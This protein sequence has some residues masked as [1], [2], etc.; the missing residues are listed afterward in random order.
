MRRVLILSDAHLAPYVQGSGPWLAYRRREESPDRL[1]ASVIDRALQGPAPLDV[2][3][4]GDLFDF[5]APP[6]DSAATAHSYALARSDSGAAIAMTTI[7]V[8][9]APFFA[10]LGRVLQRGGRV[11]VLPGNHDAQLAFPSVQ[12]VLRTA[13]GNAPNLILRPWFHKDGELF[14]EHGHQ[15]D[16][17]CAMTSLVP[18]P[19]ARG[20]GYPSQLEDTVGSVSTHFGQAVFGLSNP[21]VADPFAQGVTRSPDVRE[22]LG[23]AIANPS[24]LACA[25]SALRELMTLDR[26]SETAATSSFAPMPPHAVLAAQEVAAPVPVLAAHA[27]LA[28][29]K[30]D[31]ASLAEAASRA[32]DYG[33]DVEARQLEAMRRIGLLYSSRAV[34]MGHTHA[35]FVRTENGVSLVNSGSWVPASGDPS[36]PAGTFVDALVDP[37]GRLRSIALRRAHRDGTVE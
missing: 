25:M 10:A 14:I 9:H 13:F 37:G 26:K 36:A 12:R 18:K 27:R 8:D 4:A 23:I 11:I 31:G 7:L 16:P 33:A 1:L 3:L 17:L 24:H 6:D 20:Y 28:A 22:S 29:P 32:I 30:A 19:N 5:D 21:Y 35:P 15:Y 2:V 34:V